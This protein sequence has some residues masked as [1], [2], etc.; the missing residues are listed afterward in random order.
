L[1]AQRKRT[2]RKGSRF[3]WFA[4]G[5]LPCAAHNMQTPRKVAP[6][7]RVVYQLF[8]ALLGGVKWQKNKSK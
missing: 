8:A 6:L 7:R 5:E 3:T 4:F 2:K 1:L